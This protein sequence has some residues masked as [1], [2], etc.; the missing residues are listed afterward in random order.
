MENEI[1]TKRGLVL[2]LIV[3][4][5]IIFVGLVWLIA[6]YFPWNMLGLQN[7]SVT[8]TAVHA[9]TNCTHPISYW[10][11]H[12]EL[13]PSQMVIGGQVYGS[14]DISTILSED[15]QEITGLLQAQL[16]AAFLNYLAG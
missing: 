2:V 10:R 14:N 12:P 16:L 9:D 8:P 11:E 1:T 4:T 3:A 7:P 6:T 13:Y 15:P 5:V